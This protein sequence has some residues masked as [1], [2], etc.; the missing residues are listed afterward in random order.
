MKPWILLSP[1]FRLYTEYSVVTTSANTATINSIFL[2]PVG[3]FM[4]IPFFFG[5]VKP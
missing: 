3:V 1:V 4:I 5:G 2:S